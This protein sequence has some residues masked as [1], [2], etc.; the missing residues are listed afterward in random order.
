MVF[1]DCNYEKD[2]LILNVLKEAV[3]N[4]KVN[5]ES[6]IPIVAKEIFEEIY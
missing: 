1:I 6:S 3:K 4:V 5:D 2:E